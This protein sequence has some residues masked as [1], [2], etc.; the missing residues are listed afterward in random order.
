MS[1]FDNSLQD[2]LR[3]FERLT[4]HEQKLQLASEWCLC[5][6]RE[7]AKLLIC[8]NGGS[9]SEAQHL[10]G[11][12]VGRYKESRH[13]LPAMALGT[14]AAVLTCIG[15][16]YCFD[17]IFERQ[18]RALGRTNDILIVFTTSGNSKNV[19][20]ALRVAKQIGVKTVAFLGKDGGLAKEIADCAI[21][22]D[23]AD[24]ARIQ[25]AH[26]FLMH[27]LMDMIEAGIRPN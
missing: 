27:S 22:I 5:A 25:E 21:V 7:N 2:A 19:L 11:E 23:H 9:A 14:D 12:L 13:P 15:N 1:E 8:G 10:A 6:V 26:Q 4:D 24:T 18:V 17:E 3:V 16:D 20:A